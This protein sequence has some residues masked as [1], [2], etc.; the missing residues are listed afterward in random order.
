M[1]KS[2][3]DI[4]YQRAYNKDNPW[5]KTYRNIQRRCRL[6]E[7]DRNYKH[8]KGIK[9]F[10]SVSDLKFLWKRDSAHLLKQPSIDRKDSKGHYTIENCRYIELKENA[11]LGRANRKQIVYGELKICKKCG[12]N[13]SINSFRSKSVKHL[14]H[15]KHT[16]CNDCLNEVS[17]K[18]RNSLPKQVLMERNRRYAKKSYKLRKLAKELE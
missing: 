8:Y 3:Y 12:K 6:S 10:L 5:M 14:P 16:R 13:K 1:G 15:L 9:N 11:E 4:E 18:F 17:E 2:N 7:A